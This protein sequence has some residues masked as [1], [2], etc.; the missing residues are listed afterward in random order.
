MADEKKKKPKYDLTQIIDELAPEKVNEKVEVAHR[1]ARNKYGLKDV[2]IEGYDKFMNE[3]TSYLKHHHK[4][5]F[6]SNLPDHV[7]SARARMMIDNMYEKKGGIKGAMEDASQGRMGSVLDNLAG[8]M[9]QEERSHYVQHV[10]NKID[11][12][13]FDG[14]VEMVKDYMGKYGNQLPSKFKKKSAEEL[15]HNYGQLIDAHTNIVET[16]KNVMKKYEPAK[17]AKKKA[18]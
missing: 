15:A 18:A 10:M 6:K 14:H 5:V 16:A 1:R 8:A 4:E 13:D 2:K 17:P 11:P 3:V 12:Q 9:E 7:A